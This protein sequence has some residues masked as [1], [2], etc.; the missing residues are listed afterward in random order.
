MVWGNTCVRVVRPRP[1]GHDLEVEHHYSNKEIENNVCNTRSSQDK[2]D[3]F[4]HISVCGAEDFFLHLLIVQWQMGVAF[5]LDRTP[6]GTRDIR[7]G[8]T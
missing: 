2:P 5:T 1:K 8:V 7:N 6:K 4:Y 3:R